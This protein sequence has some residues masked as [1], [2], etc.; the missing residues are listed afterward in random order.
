MTERT[1]VW[2][3]T[4]CSTGFGH[5]IVKQLLVKGIRVAVT[6]RRPENTPT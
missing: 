1:R 4:G 5:E 2:F 3:V 6:A